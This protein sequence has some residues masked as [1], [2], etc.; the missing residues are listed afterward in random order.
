[1]PS[2]LCMYQGGSGTQEAWGVSEGKK[3][4]ERFYLYI[5][6]E[7][8]FSFPWVLLF[9]RLSSMTD[10]HLGLSFLLLRCGGRPCTVRYVR[11]YAFGANIQLL[12]DTESSEC[13]NCAGIRYNGTSTLLVTW[14]VWTR[15]LG[16]TSAKLQ[17]P[18]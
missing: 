9:P 3:L 2:K 18:V 16:S 6:L 12:G 15:S 7:N 5:L 17:D 1:M 8:L 4:M 13:L 11:T 10:F 14:K